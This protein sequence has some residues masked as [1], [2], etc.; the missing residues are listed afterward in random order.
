MSSRYEVRSGEL[1]QSREARARGLES[2]QVSSEHGAASYDDP[3][4]FDHF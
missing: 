1:L 4:F 2:V 3:V